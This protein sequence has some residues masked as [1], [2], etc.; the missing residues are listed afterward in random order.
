LINI[1][2]YDRIQLNLIQADP[3]SEHKGLLLQ[4]M[5][6]LVIAPEATESAECQ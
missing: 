5:L 6:V 3:Y 2:V 4:G 1:V